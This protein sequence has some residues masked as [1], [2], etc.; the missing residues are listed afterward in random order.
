MEGSSQRDEKVINDSFSVQTHTNPQNFA[1]PYYYLLRQPEADCDAQQKPRTAPTPQLRRVSSQPSSRPIAKAP[2]PGA[3][4]DPSAAPLASQEVPAQH[5]GPGPTVPPLLRLAYDCG[6]WSGASAPA[7]QEAPPFSQTTNEMDPEFLTQQQQSK[8]RGQIGLPPGGL[9]RQ[10]C[11]NNQLRDLPM[12][13][14]V[15]S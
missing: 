13:W 15:R 2:E 9:P 7:Q 14:P 8:M 3:Q 10:A 11:A 12:H 6:L 1:V 5:C 4:S